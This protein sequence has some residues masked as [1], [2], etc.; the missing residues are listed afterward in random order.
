MFWVSDVTCMKLKDRY[1]Y[2]CAVVDLYSRKVI[3]HK[4]STSEQYT[5]NHGDTQMAYD[6]RECREK[7]DIPQ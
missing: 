2:L 1:Y 7:F 3:A 6:A 5:A 4:V